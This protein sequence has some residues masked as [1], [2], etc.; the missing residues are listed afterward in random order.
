MTWLAQSIAR[1]LVKDAPILVLDEPTAALDASTEHRVLDRLAAWGED[2]A[3]FLITHRISTIQQADRI[4][5][6]TGHDVE[7][8]FFFFLQEQ[9]GRRQEYRIPLS[10]KDIAAAIGTIPETLSR[11][12]LRLRGEKKIRW[13]GDNLRLAEGFWERFDGRAG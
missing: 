5:Y 11:L 3:I 4:L 12:L 13:E 2:R 1:A 8:R 9:F 6:L 10:K 7:E